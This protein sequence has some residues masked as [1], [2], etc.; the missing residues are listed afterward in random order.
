MQS[1]F[2]V[3]STKFP[4]KIKNTTQQRF[5]A[6]SGAFYLQHFLFKLWSIPNQWLDNLVFIA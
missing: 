4:L 6:F 2:F 3:A 5:N 1:R